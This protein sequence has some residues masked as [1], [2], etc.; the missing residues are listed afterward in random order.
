[1]CLKFN[2]EEPMKRHDWFCQIQEKLERRK[3]S[4]AQV[5]SWKRVRIHFHLGQLESRNEGTS[6]F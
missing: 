4:R 2:E 3:E 6:D 1:M 5:E